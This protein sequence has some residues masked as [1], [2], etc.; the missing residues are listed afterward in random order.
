MNHMNAKSGKKS[1][2]S[3]IGGTELPSVRL[4]CLEWLIWGVEKKIMELFQ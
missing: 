3:N 4:S 1:E 2:G